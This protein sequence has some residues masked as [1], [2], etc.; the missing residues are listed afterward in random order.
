MPRFARF[1]VPGVAHH[2]TPVSY[3]HLDVYKR[4]L[5]SQYLLSFPAQQVEPGFHTLTVRVLNRH[6]LTIRARSGYW[7]G[8]VP[9]PKE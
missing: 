8:D 5:H 4:Q 9:G 3:T 1:V 7:F 2:I 6:G